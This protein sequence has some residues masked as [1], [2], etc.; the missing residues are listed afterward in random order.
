[1]C[2]AGV[3]ANGDFEA[4]RG[5]QSVNETVCSFDEG[6]IPPWFP[7]SYRS[8]GRAVP[9][10]T[11]LLS[12]SQAIRGLQPVYEAI[13]SFDEG[14]IPPWFP[15]SCRSK[16]RAVPSSTRLLCSSQAIR[17]LQPV[18][19][20]ICSFEEGFD[21]QRIPAWFRLSFASNVYIK[22]RN[23]QLRDDLQERTHPLTQRTPINAPS[24]KHISRHGSLPR[25]VPKAE[26][27]RPRPSCFA[28]S[29]N[30]QTSVGVVNASRE[31]QHVKA[32]VS[33]AG[34]RH[35]GVSRPSTPRHRKHAY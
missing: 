23:R 24:T 26:P 34:T 7:A 27:R 13:C 25:V 8:E 29:R 30:Y 10:P 1:M 15:A 32:K 19:E 11:R 21:E 6:R 35:P 14:R 22:N 9:S 28:C 33:A 16:G 3:L 2:I 17:G 20:A 31:R 12:S 4:I 5:L 18:Y